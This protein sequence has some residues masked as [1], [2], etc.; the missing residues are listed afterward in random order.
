M[1]YYFQNYFEVT[2]WASGLLLLALFDPSTQGISLCFF[3]FIGLG[4]CPGCGLGHSI[5]W[6]FHGNFQRS[7]DAHPLGFIAVVIILTRIGTLIRAIFH[8]F[9]PTL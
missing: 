7:F 5:S 9:K 6:L 3:K 2:I 4:T 8:S 1:K